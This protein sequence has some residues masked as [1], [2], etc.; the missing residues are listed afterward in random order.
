M[1][2]KLVSA[3]TITIIATLVAMGC[4]GGNG[5]NPDGEDILVSADVVSED[6]ASANEPVMDNEALTTEDVVQ[7]T[8]EIEDAESGASETEEIIYGPPIPL[9]VS[10]QPEE[11]NYTISN[12]PEDF[13]LARS[14]VSGWDNFDWDYVDMD[15]FLEESSD[16]RTFCEDWEVIYDII[17]NQYPSVEEE[18]G[19]GDDEHV[20]DKCIDIYDGRYDLNQDGKEEYLIAFRTPWAFIKSGFMIFEKNEDDIQLIYDVNQDSTISCLF[21][22]D[23]MGH[24]DENPIE[25]V[26]V[27]DG[28]LLQNEATHSPSGELILSDDM[29][30]HTV[31]VGGNTCVENIDYRVCYDGELV[32]MEMVLHEGWQ[33][34]NNGIDVCYTRYYQYVLE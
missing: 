29:V 10:Y 33:L 32:T 31:R 7:E 18:A 19:F 28:Y 14:T 25:S 21:F 17:I 22:E 20:L 13:W 5:S 12:T 4:A 16:C 34:T 2:K 6:S 23:I 3:L 24:F 9:E 27:Q 30:L 8:I 1:K 26:R 11:M 15:V